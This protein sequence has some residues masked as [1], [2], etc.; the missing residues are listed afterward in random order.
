MT[1]PVWPE[2]LDHRPFASMW[3]L[4]PFGDPL[5]TDM[6]A[7]NQRVRPRPWQ[8]LMVAQWGRTFLRQEMEDHFIPFVVTTLV[9]GT[10]RFRMPLLLGGETC[11]TRTVQ[12]QPGTLQ[13]GALIGRKVQVAMGLTIFPTTVLD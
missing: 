13:Y 10:I 7:G 1:A 11:E 8:S 9:Y 5:A 4:K 12:I 2:A 3:S 6:E